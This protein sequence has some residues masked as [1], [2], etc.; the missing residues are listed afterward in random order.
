MGQ[1][2][3]NIRIQTQTVSDVRIM[4]KGSSLDKHSELGQVLR[5]QRRNEEEY[6][7]GILGDNHGERYPGP[8]WYLKAVCDTGDNHPPPYHYF[9]SLSIFPSL[10]FL[11]LL[12]GDPFFATPHP[13][14]LF[15]SSLNPSTIT[16]LSLHPL[17]SL[18]IS[19]SIYPPLPCGM[20]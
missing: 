4:D 20:F 14:P 7:H 5:T 10:T 2:G 12:R 11:S 6:F 19:L 15:S 17:Q 3:E 13:C 1:D 18:F 16:H 9:P 8:Q